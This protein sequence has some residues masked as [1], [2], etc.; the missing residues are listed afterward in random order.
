[1]AEP[2]QPKTLS[3]LKKQLLSQP[4]QTTSVRPKTLSELKAQT[5]D[6]PAQ[7]GIS[8]PKTLSELKAQTFKGVEEGKVGA[9]ENLFRFGAGAIRD[10]SQV[11]KDNMQ[12]SLAWQGKFDPVKAVYSKLIDVTPDLPEIEQPTT[13][14]EIKGVDIPVGSFARDLAGFAIPYAGLSKAAGPI[15]QGASLLQKGIRSATLGT[16]AEQLAFS[17]TEARLSNFV[18]SFPSLQNPVTEFLQADEDDPRS[19]ARLKMAVEGGATGVAFELIFNGLRALKNIRKKDVPAE[20][21]Q[22]SETAVQKA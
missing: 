4:A 22:I 16:V 3:E 13:S 17:P 2:T 18:Q 11:I 9:I 10:T 5:S 6:Q 15:R 12:E 8:K 20:T 19:V 21:K 14:V 7:P 1:M